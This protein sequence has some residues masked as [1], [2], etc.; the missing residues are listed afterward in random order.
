MYLI[1]IRHG[2][3]TFLPTHDPTLSDK[4]FSQASE[5]LKLV[6][7][8]VLAGP[9]MCWVSDS[10]RTYQTVEKIIKHYNVQCEK[11]DQLSVRQNHESGSEFRTR[12]AKTISSLE[13]I[14]LESRD[15]VYMLCTH[16][17]WIEEAMSVINC[18]QNL[19][20][21]EYS[22]WAPAQYM[23]FEIKDSTWYVRDKG[24]VQG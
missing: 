6:E 17:D 8:G 18:D 22:H 20:S 5:L 1:L 24:V 14:A 11:T 3:K 12:V 10:Q 13:Q 4:G 19:T 21:F 7:K 23:V 15:K 16:F 9:N 2:H